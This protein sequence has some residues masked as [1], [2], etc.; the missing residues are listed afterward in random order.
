M[1]SEILKRSRENIGDRTGRLS[2]LGGISSFIHADG[3]A[4]GISTL[5]IRTVPGL[6]Y[7]I[8][9]DRGMDIFECSWRGR[10][11]C[12]HSPVGLVHPAYYSNQGVEWLRTFG[13]GMLSTCGLTSA[14]APSVDGGESVGL[15]GSLANTPAEAVQWSENWTDDD[16]ELTASG[17]VREVS[18]LGHNLL[19]K[20]TIA[21]SLHSSR[22]VIHDLVENQ[23]LKESPLML[24]DHFNFGYPLL[25][26]KS[27][28][29][30]KS[31]NIE[32]AT[33]L[34]GQS[35]T[36]WDRFESPIFGIEERVYFHEMESDCDGM[37]TIVLLSDESAADFG[38]S[39]R[40]CKATLPEFVQWKMPG[41]N[42]Y[43][44]GLE[45]ANCRSLGRAAERARGTLEALAPGE[46][47]EFTIELR[48]LDGPEE[49]AATVREA[50]LQLP[51]R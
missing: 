31:R 5:R 4:K 44:M 11:L 9:P 7:W 12:W 38:I 14:G 36:E 26:P 51:R 15:H 6:E 50:G 37:V 16:Y 3:R 35:I 46:S 23:G 20:R 29:L 21:T 8:V 28:L 22:V 34:A 42:H 32:P 25:T 39:L 1:N 18:V 2:Q 49:V 27:C 24:L 10:S 30:A 19:L 47:S 33:E 17:H 41:T 13:G 45:P 40:Y 43:V 48:V